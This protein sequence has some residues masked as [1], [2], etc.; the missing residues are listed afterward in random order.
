MSARREIDVLEAGRIA[1]LR[2]A[3]PLRESPLLGVPPFGVNRAGNATPHPGQE[4]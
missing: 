1:E 2:V 4:S 3:Q